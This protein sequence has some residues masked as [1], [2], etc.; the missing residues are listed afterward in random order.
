MA[1]CKSIYY[2]FFDFRLDVE[3]QQLL[4]NGE[5]VQLTHK[6]FQILLLLVQNSGQI[7]KKEDIFAELWSDS[8]VEDGN[9]TQ[10]IYVLRKVLGQTPN[11]Q[12]YIE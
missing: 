6:A 9:L 4:K 1:V 3:K 12:S 5:P 2:D 11:G 10:Q 8:F 7:T